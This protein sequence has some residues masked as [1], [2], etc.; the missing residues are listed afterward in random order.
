M[1]NE[2]SLSTRLKIRSLALALTSQT[3]STFV[4]V[5]LPLRQQVQHVVS[6]A[7]VHQEVE[8]SEDLHQIRVHVVQFDLLDQHEICSVESVG[9]SVLAVS[10]PVRSEHLV[11]HLEI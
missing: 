10:S 3:R 6:D 2:Y 1:L 9:C 5:G 7:D 11:D 8:R 4:D